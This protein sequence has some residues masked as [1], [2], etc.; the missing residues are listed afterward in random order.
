[1][2][3]GDRHFCPTLVYHALGRQ[4]DA[5]HELDLFKKVKGDANPVDCAQIYAQ[6]GNASDAMLWLTKAE[7]LHDRGLE[8]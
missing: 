6:W 8:C 2:F 4:A 1:M 5:E 3:E 7:R